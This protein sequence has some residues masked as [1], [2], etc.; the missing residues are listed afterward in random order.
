VQVLQG[1]VMVFAVA[2][3]GRL[4]RENRRAAH[5]RLRHRLGHAHDDADLLAAIGGWSIASAASST[6]ASNR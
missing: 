1:T 2:Q 3:L 5:D 6:S 4:G